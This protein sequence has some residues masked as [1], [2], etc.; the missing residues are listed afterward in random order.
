MSEPNNTQFM[1]GQLA[2]SVQALTVQMK[3]LKA[4]VDTLSAHMN[5]TKGGF[6]ILLAVGSVSTAVGAGIAWALQYFVGKTPHG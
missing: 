4:T 5:Q 1:L 2:S 6:R 3:E